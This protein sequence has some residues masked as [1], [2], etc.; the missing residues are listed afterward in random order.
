MASRKRPQT[1]SPIPSI[2]LQITQKTADQFLQ[3]SA[4]LK[5]DLKRIIAKVPRDEHDGDTTETS[6]PP[7]FEDIYR[8]MF[9]CKDDSV[10]SFVQRLKAASLQVNEEKA[11]AL[12]FH[13][14]EMNEKLKH[15]LAAIMSRKTGNPT[16]EDF[17]SLFQAILTGI[18]CCCEPEKSEFVVEGKPGRVEGPSPKRLKTEDATESTKPSTE[19]SDSNKDIRDCQSPSFDS[20]LATLQDEDHPEVAK[21]EIAEV[22]NYA[23]DQLFTF[24]QGTSRDKITAE[25]I[26]EWYNKSGRM[27]VPW[28]ELLSPQKWESASSTTVTAS[29]TASAAPRTFKASPTSNSEEKEPDFCNKENETNDMGRGRSSSEGQNSA[30]SENETKMEE[31]KSADTKMPSGTEENP[32]GLLPKPGSTITQTK[33]EDSSPGSLLDEDITSRTLVSFDFSGSGHPTPL[34]IN[35]SE[36]NLYALRHFVHRTGLMHCPAPEICKRL[37]RLATRRVFG[38][39]ALLTLQRDTWL[40][41]IDRL[42]GR[43]AWEQLSTAEQAAFTLCLGDIFACYEGSKSFLRSDEVDLQEFSVGFCFFCAG[44][45]SSK[46]ATGFEMLDDKRKSS[47]SQEELLRYLNSY[48]TMLVAMSLLKPITHRNIPTKLSDAKRQKLRQAV[49]SGSRWTLSHF[50]KHLGENDFEAR[51]D[52]FSFEKFASWY[53]SGGYEV[54]PWLELLDLSKVFSLLGSSGIALEPH[55]GGR[56]AQPLRRRDRVS[57]LRRHHSTRRGPPPEVLFTF[58]VA[59]Q[60]SLVVLRDDAYYVRSVVQELGL[61]SMNPDDL[62]ASLSSKVEQQRKL[63]MMG[64]GAVYV[65]MSTF[66]GAMQSICPM[67]RSR[68]SAFR[69]EAST[70][71][72]LSNFFQCFDLEANDNVALDELMGGLT[73]LCGGKKSHK[74][75]FAFGVFDTRPGIQEKK[76]KEGITHSLSGEDLFLFLRSILI[77]TFSCCRQSLDMTDGMVARCIADTA[78]MICND[79]MRHQWERRRKDRLNFDEF[80]QWYND[81]G[82][83]TAPWLELLDLKKW[84]LI[85][86]HEPE[87]KRT[88]SSHPARQVH[89]NIDATVPPPPPEDALDADFFESTIMPMDSVSKHLCCPLSLI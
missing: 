79:V 27:L 42:L 57:S 45:K 67:S 20:S 76:R 11:A 61:L 4:A 17:V 7:L 46:L 2:T 25:T 69:S 89:R 75:A 6:G 40:N 66:V 1:D 3:A 53:S 10:F 28:M 8:A 5:L 19:A 88:E 14:S 82:Y 65:G 71:E 24:S 37:L 62:W 87:P 86:D 23:A 47:L 70:A 73:L 31:T 72:L 30:L 83:E 60:S 38:D 9:S 41:S 18:M 49:E 48:L 85:D 78:N 16:K 12:L 52:S 35:I 34:C 59:N 74:L 54:A 39:E 22:A 50:V 84:V 63:L 58:P 81:G 68:N 55:H 13:D 33:S 26:V 56:A 43:D 80:G 15:S 32:R 36:D 77:V 29:N 64:P 44:N 21:K 51:K